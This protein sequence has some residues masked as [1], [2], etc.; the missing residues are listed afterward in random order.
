MGLSAE[1]KRILSLI[2]TGESMFFTGCAG[3]G[4]SYMLNAAIAHL[5]K[6][7]PSNSVYV[8][9]STGIAATHIGGITL[10]SFA[11]IGLGEGPIDKIIR[12]VKLNGASLY[13]WKRARVLII[14]EISMI[15]GDLLE[16]IDTVARAV[17]DEKEKPMGGIQVIATGDFLQLPPVVKR[18]DKKKNA[19]FAFQAPCWNDLFTH[20]EVLH[21]VYRQENKAFVKL[22]SEMRMG[23]ITGDMMCSLDRTKE[24]TF[25]ADGILPT[26]LYSHRVDVNQRNQCELEKLN[27]HPVHTYTSCDTGSKANM[28]SLAKNCIAPQCVKLRVGAQVMLIANI[29]V[30]AGLAN[31]SRGVVTG[32]ARNASSEVAQYGMDVL[33]KFTNGKTIAISPRSGCW[34]KREGDRVRASRHQIPLILAWAITVHKRFASFPHTP[35]PRPTNRLSQGMTLDRV[36]MDLSRVFEYAMAYVAVSRATSMSTMRL[37]GTFDPTRVK[38]AHPDAVKYYDQLHKNGMGTLFSSFH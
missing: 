30:A 18:G 25:P 20:E 3:T 26:V 2:D 36:E 38:L 13:R 15:S 7:H 32:F 4:K 23:R 37:T 22:L 9:A 5:R 1:Q 14:D 21:R 19:L 34:E 16:L 8:T 35:S 24:N 28:A 27:T 10:H 33:V 6:K 31:G 17:R 12:K 29:R 11:G